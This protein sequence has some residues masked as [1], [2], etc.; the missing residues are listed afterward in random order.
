MNFGSLFDNTNGGS[1][2]GARILSGLTYGNHTTVIPGGAMA[3]VAAASLFSPPIN[4]KT[5]Y[6]SGLSLALVRR[7]ILY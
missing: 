6:S 5:V 1:P 3:Q 2:T 7:R 4:T